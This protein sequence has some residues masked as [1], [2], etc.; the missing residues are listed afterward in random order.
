MNLRQISLALVFLSTVTAFGY[1]RYKAAGESHGVAQFAIIRDTS[2]S[3]ED[4]CGR[5]VGLAE[6]ALGTPRVGAG[7]EIALF[8]LGDDKTANEPRLLGEFKVPVI[9]RV[10]EGQRAAAREREDILSRLQKRC[11]EA[12]QT[13]VS[14]IFQAVKRGVEHLQSVGSPSDSRYLFV[15]TDGEETANDQIKRAIS[16]P[17]AKLKLPAPI[18]NSGVRV[19]FCGMAETVGTTSAPNNKVRHLSRLRDA[20]R[21]DRLREVWAGVFAEPQLVSFEPFCSKGEVRRDRSAKAG[22]E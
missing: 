16:T 7:S 19:V 2:D 11:G 6:R 5:V 15:Q 9:R 20:Q 12:G 21:P 22:K 8:A 17:G 14:P 13:Q 1:W 3:I 10:I 18:Q 4:D